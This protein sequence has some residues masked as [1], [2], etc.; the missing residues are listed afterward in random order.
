MQNVENQGDLKKVEVGDTVKV[1]VKSYASSKT[2]WFN[3][4]VT[5]SAIIEVLTQQPWVM[6]H[7]V[8]L[9]WLGSAVGVINIIL[10]FL[11]ISPVKLD[12]PVN[13]G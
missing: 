2:L 10:R 9:V 8:L 11:T 13:T 12:P 7:A 5:L 3:A 4:L 1:D 6:S